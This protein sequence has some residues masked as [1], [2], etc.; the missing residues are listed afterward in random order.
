MRSLLNFATAIALV[1]SAGCGTPSKVVET[2]LSS[3]P[4][5]VYVGGQQMH[6][7]GIAL[8]RAKGFMYFSFTNRFLKT[9]LAGNVLASI[10]RI[11][12]HLGAM[13]L[14]PIDGRV[15]ASLECKD[16]EIGSNIAGKMNVGTVA[17]GGSHF[18]IAII[19]VDRL[20]R[21][22]MDPE[23]DKIMWTVNIAEAALDYNAE[24]HRYGCSGID[25]VTFAPKRGRRDGKMYL[26]VAYGIYGD[27]KRDDN[28]NQI[29]LC[30]DPVK[31]AKYETELVFGDLHDKGPEKP[32]EKHFIHT[33]N[34]TWGVQNLAWDA[35]TGYMFMA[36]YKGKKAE[37]PNYDL[38][39]LDWSDKSSKDVKGWYFK[40]GA[41]G[42]C[43]VG[44][45]Y[46]IISENAK[47]RKTKEESCTARLYKFEGIDAKVPFKAA[48]EEQD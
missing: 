40:W 36:V 22:G 35:H 26:Y 5:T 38:F 18:Y 6:V 19:D 7:Q 13:T 44:S 41:T 45:G 4:G 29:I 31:F 8:D 10:D 20:D 1:F 23:K 17:S 3:L 12:G 25:G 14:S 27:V 28:D 42:L 24:G 43:P 46:W 15:Y 48:E 11:Q 9:D 21:M 37:Y 39:A 34:T 33:G 16:D 47:N 2:E 30:Y 32:L